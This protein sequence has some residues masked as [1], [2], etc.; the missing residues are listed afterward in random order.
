[1]CR[2][3]AGRRD[4]IMDAV[5]KRFEVLLDTILDAT[6]SD[7]QQLEFARLVDDHPALIRKLIE[8][9]RTHSLLQWQCDE[10][11]IGKV[12]LPKPSENCVMAAN[13][14]WLPAEG[15]MF[16]W[17]SSLAAVLVLVIAAI[18]W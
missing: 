3:H 18:F 12:H 4:S 7:E 2:D 1:M 17:T 14:S 10:V 9:L 8:Q 16:G 13:S 5:E 6:G 15:R 11:R